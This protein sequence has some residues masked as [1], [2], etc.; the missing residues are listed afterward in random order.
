MERVLQFLHNLYLEEVIELTNNDREIDAK[1]MELVNLL[2]D[3]NKMIDRDAV[4]YSYKKLREQLLSESY[5]EPL[6]K[7]PLRND[8]QRV[9]CYVCNV[10]W[11]FPAKKIPFNKTQNNLEPEKCWYCRGGNTEKTCPH[12]K[13]IYKTYLDVCPECG[14][15]FKG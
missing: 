2:K 6:S 9:R 8:Y 14:F 10:Q 11:D 12:C 15:Q 5:F 1:V 3:K 4:K 7:Q 13:S